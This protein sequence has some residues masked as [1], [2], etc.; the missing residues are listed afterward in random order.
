MATLA[1]VDE[2][3]GAM[4]DEYRALVCKVA[5]D[6]R[7]TTTKTRQVLF[8]CGKTPEDFRSDV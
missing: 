2:L 5:R 3:V 1:V 7:I 4:S 6:E 8:G